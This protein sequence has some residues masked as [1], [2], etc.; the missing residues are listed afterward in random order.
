ME[1][2]GAMRH[3]PLGDW[4]AE[5]AVLHERSEHLSG[6]EPFGELVG[7]TA[8]LFDGA[9]VGFLQIKGMK[10][11]SCLPEVQ[12]DGKIS[13]SQEDGIVIHVYFLY[14]LRNQKFSGRVDFL[15]NILI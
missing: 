3:E 13:M 7:G 11:S 5:E 14:L 12:G 1:E 9:F 8:A 15:R 10:I 6:G 4:D 2:A